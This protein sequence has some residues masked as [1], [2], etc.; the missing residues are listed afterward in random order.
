MSQNNIEV[1]RRAF[2]GFNRRDLAAAGETLH[3]DA[4]WIPYLASLE[5][6]A[7][8]GREQIVA[9][10]REVI[11]EVPDIRLELIEV[12]KDLGDTIVT[13]VEFQGMGRASGADIRTTLF[14]VVWFRDGQVARVEGYRD[15]RDALAA[16]PGAGS[17]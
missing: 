16:V 15:R 17:S 8:S 6:A 5:E 13:Q 9:M 7:Y 1:A 3:P 12:L 2:D 4:V 10:W 11:R 14:Q